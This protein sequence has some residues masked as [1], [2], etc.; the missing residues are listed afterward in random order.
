VLL[1]GL[2]DVVHFDKEFVR[3]EWTA[4][5]RITAHFADGTSASGDVLVGADG[6]GS[7][8][9]RQLLP[10]AKVVETGLIGLSGKFPLTE[11]N[12]AEFPWLFTSRYNLIM[13]PRGCGMFIAPFIRPQAGA[14]GVARDE[15]DRLVPGLLDDNLPD[16]VFWALLA[17]RERFGANGAIG[18]LAGTDVQRLA[19]QLIDGWHPDLRR[20]VTGS[21]PRSAAAIPLQNRSLSPRGRHRT[22]RCSAMPSTP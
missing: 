11:Q 19:L 6:V 20:L 4:A 5:G 1:A 3:F 16:H 2:D 8:V 18:R 22:S 15:C 10:Q 9:R 17:R 13:A 14:S 21:D 12:R 7:T